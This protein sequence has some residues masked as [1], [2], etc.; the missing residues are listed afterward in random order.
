MLFHYLV[1]LI[2][3]LY[4]PYRRSRVNKNKYDLVMSIYSSQHVAF[5]RNFDRNLFDY[6]GGEL[7][8]INY[9]KLLLPFTKVFLECGRSLLLGIECWDST[10][11]FLRRVK[12]EK[13][14]PL[15][16]S[17]S[18][19][20]FWK[21]GSLFRKVNN[22][23]VERLCDFFLPDF[24]Y[25]D[26]LYSDGYYVLRSG[27]HIYISDNLSHWDTIYIGKRGIKDSMVFVGKGKS[28]SLLFIEYSP[29]K[30]RSRHRILKYNFETGITESVFVFYT[31]NEY[32]SGI[33]NVCARHV[34]VIQK[35]PFTNDIFVGTGD[36][37]DESG[38]FVSHDDGNSFTTVKVG[39][40]NYRALSFI[41]TKDYVFWNTDTHET[42]AIFRMNK[43]DNTDLKRFPLINGALWCTAKYPLQINGDDLYIMT[44]N[45][46]GALYDNNNRV[47]GIIIRDN[48]PHIYELLKR[49]S[50]TQYSQQ[51][52]LG[53]DDQL[54]I[55]LYDHEV[56]KVNF[57]RLEIYEHQ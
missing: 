32:I 4:F 2:F 5:I 29:G 3:K 30:E 19:Y 25:C 9:S 54:N 33:G 1:N 38:I 10:I 12:S 55:V 45:S 39:S 50:R 43:S 47:Y 7:K 6:E 27:G 31:H 52:L 41:F 40:Q 48:I 21:S 34:H 49:P 24:M 42:Q 51:F 15:F 36:N 37:D 11:F 28:L 44:S 23:S 22:N 46:E 18:E 20:I 26:M 17:D 16:Y 14:R 8:L 53:F 35:D 57:Y 13:I 56:D